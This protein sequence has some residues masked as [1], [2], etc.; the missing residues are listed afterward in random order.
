[1]ST[2]M[3]TPMRTI[4]DNT[5]NYVDIPEL[6][7]RQCRVS[8]QSC[9][10][11]WHAQL[12]T[13]FDIFSQGSPPYWMVMSE[14]INSS[15]IRHTSIKLCKFLIKS[16]DGWLFTVKLDHKA[17]T[18]NKTGSPKN[19][20]KFLIKFSLLSL[21]INNIQNLRELAKFNI[22]YNCK[23]KI[24]CIESV[25]SKQIRHRVIEIIDRVSLMNTCSDV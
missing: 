13:L 1:M 21:F 5:D 14:K 24:S 15:E 4:N 7:W 25:S 2:K 22:L 6:G 19:P 17:L 16:A 8:I 18:I 12:K 3:T 10:L 9:H 23:N 20:L 11:T